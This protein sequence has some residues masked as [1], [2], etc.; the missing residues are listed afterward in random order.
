M[1]HQ[2]IALAVVSGMVHEVAI[3]EL[4]AL[5]VAAQASTL[6]CLE[7]EAK[8]ERRHFICLLV[9]AE[10]GVRCVIQEGNDFPRVAQIARTV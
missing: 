9:G 3:Y 7:A 2:S 6:M 5:L 4:R 8:P 1:H 10:F